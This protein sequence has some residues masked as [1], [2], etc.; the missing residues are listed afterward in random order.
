MCISRNDSSTFYADFLYIYI[1]LAC[2]CDT[3]GSTGPDCNQDGQCNCK[4]NVIGKTCSQCAVSV[5]FDTFE[6]LDNYKVF[7][8]L[9]ISTYNL[10]GLYYNLEG[11]WCSCV[12]F[13]KVFDVFVLWWDTSAMIVVVYS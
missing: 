7:L 8:V 3:N 5:L 4:R 6:R 12:V 2:D 1:F 10:D 13:Q 9:T 11:L